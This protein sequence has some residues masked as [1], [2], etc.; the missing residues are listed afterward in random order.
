MNPV[1]ASKAGTGTSDWIILDPKLQNGVGVAVKLSGSVTYGVEVTYDNVFNVPGS[2][3]TAWPWAGGPLPGTTFIAAT[4][5]Q[6]GFMQQTPFAVR[7]N[8]SAGAGTSTIYVFE[9]G[10]VG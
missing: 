7:L 2:S 3:I 5:A 10:R 4:A 1:T 9:Q 8:N 6:Q